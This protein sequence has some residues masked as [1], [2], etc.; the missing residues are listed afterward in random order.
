MRRALAILALGIFLGGSVATA[1]EAE[2]EPEPEPNG[3]RVDRAHAAVSRGVIGAGRRF[4]RFFSD[5]RLEEEVRGSRIRLRG[6][7]ELRRGPD[8]DLF[9]DIDAKI[10]LPRTE[11]RFQLLL[12]RVGVRDQEDDELLADRE[13]ESE[14]LTGL[15]VLLRENTWLR[16]QA[17][18]GSKFRPVPDPFTRL[19][20]RLLYELDPWAFR[21]TE[22]G[23]W[24]TRDGYGQTTRVDVDRELG[25]RFF[26]RAT[27][28]A[29]VSE[30]SDGIEWAQRLSFQR[31]LSRRR[32]IA[33]DVEMFGPT[34]PA[35]YVDEY[36]TSVRYRQRIW[37][38]WLFYELEPA[39]VFPRE[40]GYQLR[41]ELTFR[42]EIVLGD[43]D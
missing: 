8:V 24:F 42:L 15:R 28:E 41:P 6:G 11:Q 39:L 12:G 38:E 19:R 1:E 29:T 7:F 43:F 21:L 30:T 5:E 31:V 3:N 13:R 33:F 10:A 34:K 4:D 37:R 27:G 18:G 17:D 25:E 9:E 2:P 23:F 16:L 22:T 35:T 26:A 36:E 14:Y 20:A 32:A 40:R